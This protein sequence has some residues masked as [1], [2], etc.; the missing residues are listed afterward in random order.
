[1]AGIA[2]EFPDSGG[3]GGQAGFGYDGK[4]ICRS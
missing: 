3:G 1:M 4:T 2:L